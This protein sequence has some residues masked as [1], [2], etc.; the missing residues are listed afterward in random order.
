M[1]LSVRAAP[2]TKG[3]LVRNNPKDERTA[4]IMAFNKVQGAPG[5]GGGVQLI[6][7]SKE[8]ES[9]RQFVALLGQP[10]TGGPSITPAKLFDGVRTEPARRA[11]LV[12]AGRNPTQAEYDAIKSGGGW[13]ASGRSFAA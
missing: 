8:F 3:A 9:L 2:V 4:A 11:A 6:A 1:P 12:F 13:Q 10:G 7:G 5:H